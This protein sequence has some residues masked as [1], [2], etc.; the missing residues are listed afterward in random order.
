MR[1]GQAIPKY[2]PTEGHKNMALPTDFTVQ[3]L[4]SEGDF[5]THAID[6]AAALRAMP[7]TCRV[8]H[9]AWPAMKEGSKNEYQ[10]RRCKVLDVWDIFVGTEPK[11]DAAKASA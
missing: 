1:A 6:L 7:C 2:Q 11:P 5:R 3:P 8:P 4:H 10:C 9:L